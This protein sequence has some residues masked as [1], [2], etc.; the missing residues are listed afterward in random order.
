MKL[1]SSFHFNF[2]FYGFQMVLRL[3]TM[4]FTT[5]FCLNSNPGENLK[6]AIKGFRF[7]TNS[8]LSDSLV[9]AGHLLP[10]TLITIEMLADLVQNDQR[11]GV[12]LMDQ[13][14]AD[15]NDC[16]YG[17]A[18]N[19]QSYFIFSNFPKFPFNLLNYIFCLKCFS[20]F[21]ILHWVSLLFSLGRFTPPGGFSKS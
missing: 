19:L 12:N 3:F 21:V 14:Q 18:F 13:K 15:N 8:Y 16:L 17:F 4:I 20:S 10:L 9:I 1:I 2:N 7:G 5:C 11:S 6:L